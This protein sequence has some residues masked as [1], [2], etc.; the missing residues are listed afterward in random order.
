[1]KYRPLGAEFFHAGTWMVRHDDVNILFS[2]FFKRAQKFYVP[3]P[4]GI[5]IFCM[6]L[7]K[8]V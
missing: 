7:I 5:D 3:P 2:Q 4:E 8:T 6:L 1:M